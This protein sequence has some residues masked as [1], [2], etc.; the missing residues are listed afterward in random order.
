MAFMNSIRPNSFNS[1]PVSAGS[2]INAGT[3]RATVLGGKVKRTFDIIF[4][5]IGIVLLLPLLL[6]VAIVVKITSR[7]PALYGHKRIGYGGLVFKCWK[8]R[9]MMTDGKDVLER[10]LE[11]HP[12]EKA[13]WVKNRKL[14]NDP[15]VTRIGRVLRAYSIDELPQ[16]LNVLVG[17]MSFVG[18]R[19]VVCDELNKY[20]SAAVHYLSARPGVTGL[21]QISGR[22][23]VCYSERITL[24]S[25]YVQSWSFTQD[26]A[27]IAR[28]IPAVVSAKGS[29]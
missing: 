10:Y 26:C 23:D 21:W 14:K 20:G 3:A 9:S 2:A 7:G 13:E 27:I 24:D 4:A 6:L 11:A 22:S 17:E 25:Q 16:L 15:R 28:T 5:I 19:P 18:P 1:D 12:E 8:F 29:Y